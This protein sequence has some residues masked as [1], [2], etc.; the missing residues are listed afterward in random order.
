MTSKPEEDQDLCFYGVTLAA[1]AA[2]TII[3]PSY[4][5]IISTYNNSSPSIDIK[6]T[7]KLS[8]SKNALGREDRFLIDRRPEKRELSIETDEIIAEWFIK[9]QIHLGVYADTPEK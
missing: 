7:Q 6:S 5:E 2:Y 1:M 4:F 8:S 9:S 3:N